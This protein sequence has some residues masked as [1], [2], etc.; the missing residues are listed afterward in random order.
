MKTIIYST[1]LPTLLIVSGALFQPVFAQTKNSSKADSLAMEH[2]CELLH[3]PPGTRTKM[4][5]VMS[6]RFVRYFS[7]GAR[8]RDAAASIKSLSK[9]ASS[10]VS[11]TDNGPYVSTIWENEFNAVFD[12]SGEWET[13]TAR[14]P[15]IRSTSDGSFLIGY[16]THH[17][18]GN[19]DYDIF[20][21]DA[22]GKLLWT[23]RFGGPGSD[24]LYSSLRTDDDGY[25]LVGL[26]RSEAGGDKTD[27]AAGF[28]VVK[29]DKLG[30]KEWD[31]SYGYTV[32]L[33]VVKDIFF[34]GATF[35]TDGNILLAAVLPLKQNNSQALWFVKIT[36]TGQKIWEKTFDL[37]RTPL[38]VTDL[39]QAPDGNFFALGTALDRPDGSTDYWLAKFDAQGT[40]LWDKNFSG[41]NGNDFLPCATVTRDGNILLTG[42][43]DS[44]QGGDKS[45]DAIGEFDTWIIKVNS[46]GDKIWDKTIPVPHDEVVQT[47]IELPDQTIMLGGFS[48]YTSEAVTNCWISKLSSEGEKLYDQYLG[49]QVE[50]LDMNYQVDGTLCILASDYDQTRLWVS[51]LSGQLEYIPLC[52]TPVSVTRSTTVCR[53]E[54]V[55]L[56]VLAPGVTSAWKIS[57]DE[58]TEALGSVDH[59][60][61]TP[62]TTTT[63]TVTLEKQGCPPLDHDIT[64]TVAEQPEVGLVQEVETCLGNSFTLEAIEVEGAKY[65]WSPVGL[66]TRAITVQPSELTVYTLEVTAAN[67]CKRM[68]TFAPI[69]QGVVTAGFDQEI[70]LSD[71]AILRASG[72]DS[73]LW[74]TGE[75]SSNI[76][77]QPTTA[78][79]YTFS[80]TGTSGN[81]TSTD[82]VK[83]IVKE[84]C[85]G[86]PESFII[87]PTGTHMVELHWVEP[88]G[89]QSEYILERKDA[90]GN[91]V[92][93]AT[94]AKGTFN[95]TDLNL[96]ENTIYEYKIFSRSGTS[97]SDA[98]SGRTK[99][100]LPNMNFLRETVVTTKN[101]TPGTDLHTVD[102]MI[103][104]LS[105]EQRR[106]KWTY[107]NGLGTEIQT[108]A[109]EASPS[110]KDVIHPVYFDNFG[111][112]TRQYLS[113]VKDQQGN[114]G[115]YVEQ[116]P[117]EAEKFYQSPPDNIAST[118]FPYSETVFEDSPLGRITKQG[119]VGATWQP[120][121]ADLLNDKTLKTR[122]ELNGTN[123]VL[124]FIYLPSS[125]T[126]KLSATKFF[127]PNQLFKTKVY[128]DD[129]TLTIEYKDINN[130][131]VLKRTQLVTGLDPA[132]NRS[133]YADTYYIYDDVGH[134]VEILSPE[135][136]R[137]LKEALKIK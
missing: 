133:N 69:Y 41:N 98:A 114:S 125:K 79:E 48:Y 49:N 73:Y 61:I 28:W 18:F 122:F 100:F 3:L 15:F 19:S 111:Q 53:G 54:A 21:L 101:I 37:S 75:T 29:T 63:Y 67:G 58:E 132:M 57:D 120:A 47:V 30:Q 35:T 31:R 76:T 5:E 86:V 25:I 91:F 66:S 123:E 109:E 84:D 45:E 64:I 36:E 121:S 38:V 95:Y 42:I 102:D 9:K 68:D 112:S 12:F 136:V 83:I 10:L 6:K 113:F 126:Y 2:V 85:P 44:N 7:D 39:L 52:G 118:N 127:P 82:D 104:A 88:P 106:V 62:E 72:A 129:N 115:D 43:S 56:Q 77:F 8:S 119:S 33:S 108:I 131:V 78:G 32:Q 13:F 137:K 97:Q 17:K 59:F 34:T 74:S 116:A 16:S 107:Y 90:S 124:Q 70:C 105:K 20:K 128:D 81:C 11:A 87:Q 40:E 51:K 23:S 1:V 99:T 22:E 50:Y 96:S 24:L 14:Y 65:Y 55:D 110:G 71:K 92:T 94:L 27:N 89:T 60:I 134:V 46:N 4:I 103:G 93:I 135:G 80:V 117:D 130:R 26:S